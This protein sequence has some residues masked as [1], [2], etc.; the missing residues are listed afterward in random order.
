MLETCTI[1]APIRELRL[2]A[3]FE[4]HQYFSSITLEPLTPEFRRRLLDAAHDVDVDDSVLDLLVDSE[5]VLSLSIP[6]P[7]AMPSSAIVSASL[8][9]VVADSIA[10]RFVDCLRLFAD[11]PC[12]PSQQCWFAIIQDQDGKSDRTEIID[13]H[14]VQSESVL[15]EPQPSGVEVMTCLQDLARYERQLECWCQI[16]RLNETYTD[17]KRQ[18]GYVAAGNAAIRRGFEERARVFREEHGEDDETMPGHVKVRLTKEQ[19]A[20]LWVQGHVRAFQQ[21]VEKLEYERSVQRSKVRFL[22]GLQI[23]TDAFLVK[24]PYR[25]VV[26][27]GVLESLFGKN[28]GELS[29]QLAVR[30]AWL[31]EPDSA[32]QRHSIS[33]KVKNIY[34]LRS[35]IAHG[36]HFTIGKLEECE[37]ELLELCRQVIRTV[38]H[39]SGAY[40]ALTH[41]LAAHSD[42]FLDRLAI[43]MV[44]NELS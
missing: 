20:T 18:K 35:E 14:W 3:D 24:P 25:F 37:S 41:Q 13:K 12:L 26:R 44:D 1:S 27:V 40:L 4:R 36:A 32:S 5:A 10:R 31:L 30:I 11:T 42:D 29:Y 33:K 15:T 9:R 16:A 21:S 39:N 2:P 22:R 6:S 28:S 8:Y 19:A 34:K 7:W 43:G 17:P 38:L 23:F